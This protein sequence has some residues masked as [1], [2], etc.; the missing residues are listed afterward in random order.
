MNEISKI[1]NTIF[2]LGNLIF[3]N[4]IIALAIGISVLCVCLWFFIF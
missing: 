3:S 2:G 1:L 4:W